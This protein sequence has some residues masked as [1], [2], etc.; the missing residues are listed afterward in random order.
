MCPQ[1][2]DK[3]LTKGSCLSFNINSFQQ[4]RNENVEYNTTY[5]Y[6]YSSRVNDQQF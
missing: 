2:N 1:K 4:V 5:I 3:Q 6:V